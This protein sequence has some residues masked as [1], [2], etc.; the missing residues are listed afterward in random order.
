[1]KYDYKSIVKDL[2]PASYALKE[3]LAARNIVFAAM[4]EAVSEY[5]SL[6]YI[7]STTPD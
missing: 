6:R 1:M 3:I 2:L 7:T 5:L 4:V